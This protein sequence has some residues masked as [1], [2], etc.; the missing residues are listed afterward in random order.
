MDTLVLDGWLAC[1]LSSYC[2]ID[3]EA[4]FCIRVPVALV[5]LAFTQPLL[6]QQRALPSYVLS[7]LL[8]S[9]RGFVAWLK[10]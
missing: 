9:R 8:I 3:G 2:P 1:W 10:G 6:S 4:W 7:R 5:L